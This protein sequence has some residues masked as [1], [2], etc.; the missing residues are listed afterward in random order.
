M[1]LKN[2]FWLAKSGLQSSQRARQGDQREDQEPQLVSGTPIFIFGCL[3][4]R[5]LI[6]VPLLFLI[7]IN[8]LLNCTDEKLRLFADDA[9]AFI[10]PKHSK[11]LKQKVINTIKNINE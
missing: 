1:P 5:V 6:Q 8:D 7:Y 11:I 10:T 4:P 2:I 9:N 3:M